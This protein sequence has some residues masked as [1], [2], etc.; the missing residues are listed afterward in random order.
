MKFFQV[1]A[2]TDEPFGGNPAGVI[3]NAQGLED[4]VMQKVARELNLS[5]SAFLFTTSSKEY[6]FEIR[7]FTPT[8]EIDFC[9]HATLSA[10]WIVANELDWN[11]KEIMFKTNIGL[12]PLEIIKKEDKVSQIMMTQVEPRIKEIK[13]S[14]EELA[15][16]IGVTESDFE[17]TFPIKLSFTG[18]WHL[19]IPVKTRKAIDQAIPNMKNLRDHNIQYNIAT[20]HLFT[21]DS[22]LDHCTLYTR[23]F[24]PAVGIDEDPVTGAAN[25]ALAGYLLHEGIIEQG[26]SHQFTIAQGHS[27]GR[28]GFLHIIADNREK[29]IRIK[30]GGS[31][32]TIIKGDIFI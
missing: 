21:F 3:P 12:I 26:Q 31:A 15:K 14:R 30:V 7:Y 6:D 17:E 32:V 28:P 5:E 1:D 25:G 24:A 23:D 16:L 10:A 11:K 9:G 2:F 18:N 27:V 8:T 13:T 20:T 4:S 22:E 19:L 29:D